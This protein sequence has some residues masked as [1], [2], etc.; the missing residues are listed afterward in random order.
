M[1]PLINA[2]WVSVSPALEV[3]HDPLLRQLSQQ[4][5]IACWQYQQRWMSLFL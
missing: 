4:Q 3:F 1:A 5:T 2:L